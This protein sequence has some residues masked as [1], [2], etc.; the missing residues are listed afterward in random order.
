[1]PIEAVPQDNLIAG[2][3]SIHSHQRFV[4]TGSQ[5]EIRDQGQ[6]TWTER[7]T[8]KLRLETNLKEI[9]RHLN[10]QPDAFQIA[11]RRD[12]INFQKNIQ[13]IQK[14]YY[15]KHWKIYTLIFGRAVQDLCQT[16]SKQADDEL[17]VRSEA[18]KISPP[19]IPPPQLP[20]QVEEKIDITPP[21][22]KMPIELPRPPAPKQAPVPIPIQEKQVQQPVKQQEP[23]KQEKPPPI[24]EPIIPKLIINP[25]PPARELT[26]QDIRHDPEKV[27]EF[28]A[29]FLKDA[30]HIAYRKQELTAI[31]ELMTEEEITK[32]MALDPNGF[33][34]QAKLAFPLLVQA[35]PTS[36]L[37]H[38]V[39]LMWSQDKKS[40]V[41][42][43]VNIFSYDRSML[44]ALPDKRE[45]LMRALLASDVSVVLQEMLTDEQNVQKT[46]LTILKRKVQGL[47]NDHVR[48]AYL[49]KLA[50][51]CVEH[52]ALYESLDKDH[53]Y[54]LLDAYVL[55]EKLKD[56]H[57]DFLSF[58]QILA[59]TARGLEP[60]ERSHYLRALTQEFLPLIEEKQWILCREVWNAQ[61]VNLD[62]L[63]FFRLLCLHLKT[64]ENV[65]ARFTQ[66]LD[67]QA[68]YQ[69]VYLHIYRLLDL[70][71]DEQERSLVG[72]AIRGYFL[73]PLFQQLG[74]NP[75]LE[76][77]KAQGQPAVSLA[78][79]SLWI[80]EV[81][82]CD[83]KLAL[84]DLL[85]SLEAEEL[86]KIQRTL[87]GDFD[88]TT[89]LISY[90][91]QK[92][93]RTNTLAFQIIK[94]ALEN[95]FQQYVEHQ[96]ELFQLLTNCSETALS[97]A[98]RF[99][100]L[101]GQMEL[102][103]V[104]LLKEAFDEP[105]EMA[106]VLKTTLEEVVES[107][108]LQMISSQCF[109][110]H[111][112][113]KEENFIR[114]YLH[115][116]PLARREVFLS[117]RGK[118][119]F[120]ED[121]V[122]EKISTNRILTELL[123]Q[124]QVEAAATFAKHLY[125]QE[126]E[127]ITKLDPLVVV[128]YAFSEREDR[129][130]FL[131]LFLYA[132]Q[133]AEVLPVDQMLKL[134]KA[135]P[136]EKRAIVIEHLSP[137]LALQFFLAIPWGEAPHDVIEDQQDLIAKIR[138]RCAHVENG[139]SMQDYLTQENL[140]KPDYRQGILNLT[141]A[142]MD[143]PFIDLQESYAN[144]L[145]ESLETA[146]QLIFLTELSPET[147]AKILPHLS[148]KMKISYWLAL[149]PD[150]M[151]TEWNNL[152]ITEYPRWFKAVDEI[153]CIKPLE[154]VVKIFITMKDS[155]LLELMSNEYFNKLKNVEVLAECLKYYQGSQIA[156]IRQFFFLIKN[157]GKSLLSACIP[158][159]TFN[160]L[161]GLCLGYQR[162]N[163]SPHNSPNRLAPRPPPPSIEHY[164]IDALIE[165]SYQNEE[166]LHQLLQSFRENH[167]EQTSLKDFEQLMADYQILD[168]EKLNPVDMYLTFGQDLDRE[169]DIKAYVQ[170]TPFNYLR[171]A[172]PTMKPT[173]REQIL[174]SEE[175]LE[176]EKKQLQDYC[177]ERLLL[178]RFNQSHEIVNFASKL[179]AIIQR[180]LFGPAWE[181]NGSS[182]LAN[183]QTLTLEGVRVGFA[184]TM[185]TDS[186]LKQLIQKSDVERLLTF[187]DLLS[188]KRRDQVR[189][190]FNE[191]QK[192]A[193]D[194]MF[195]RI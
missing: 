133:E 183:W 21:Q 121:A 101:D 37:T 188:I 151:R 154:I 96:E 2:W 63:E 64:P 11:S 100:L 148:L 51:F 192:E 168:S 93:K 171:I 13:R 135:V 182:L 10:S 23:V 142:I 173:I 48:E 102:P 59:S 43:I 26:Y 32:L 77:F 71:T 39:E 111:L 52:G 195:P 80:S 123:T 156:S 190:Y 9:Q 134:G 20:I 119:I 29:A 83:Q 31:C 112:S 172:W 150:K 89:L 47:H 116:L 166:R 81:T 8:G 85:P 53:M 19:L 42:Q 49:Q 149:P 178:A 82:E 55:K 140:L 28:L 15:Q 138:I 153:L 125:P 98:F 114:F 103:L 194:K 1:M 193:V 184:R 36:K 34:L 75:F 94:G 24:P 126:K 163:R 40:Y 95:F 38:F 62:C 33:H 162:Y 189:A 106:T 145:I 108:F 56:P 69:G 124:E 185:W 46:I 68:T 131:Q 181:M 105:A 60:F 117:H 152:K 187:Y 86:N 74:F 143:D 61:H 67:T 97:A 137:S 12:L 109:I 186:E 115:L 90:A 179:P 122:R 164:F 35:M 76:H 170:S 72:A 14:D 174:D 113:S 128:D 3:A 50:T 66:L 165:G 73:S 169:A 57:L 157:G 139:L 110:N 160:Q 177:F 104:R 17:K 88:L 65:Q 79:I 70:A 180:N 22:I 54:A 5:I 27:R 18:R 158:L 120:E 191:E 45:L 78:S 99:L 6:W 132:L 136:V 25:P 159:M 16:L 147:F 87:S 144:A 130:V 118:Q 175:I 176:D 91:K 127:D 4:K 146:D 30:P 92:D 167:P 84:W 58:Q 129:D 161:R 41:P 7:L 155:K 141:E 44:Q 107:E